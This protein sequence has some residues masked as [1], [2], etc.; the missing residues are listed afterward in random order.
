MGTANAQGTGS[1]SGNADRVPQAE[2]RPGTAGGTPTGYRRRNADRDR[3]RNGERGEPQAERR[4][5]CLSGWRSNARAT[6]GSPHVG[7]L[8]PVFVAQD[9][10]RCCPS[11]P[12]GA[13]ARVG[14]PRDRSSAERFRLFGRHV[15]AMGGDLLGGDPG[16]LKIVGHFRVRLS[17]GG[18]RR[19]GAIPVVNR[20]PRPPGRRTP[21]LPARGPRNPGG[22]YAGRSRGAGT[23]TGVA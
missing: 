22:R 7:Q 10:R 9:F 21:I 16:N 12:C 14:E 2:R 11:R 5:V 23:P 15:P 18:E 19:A 6:G 13:G 20:T 4:P 17:V 3:W 8:D 1:G